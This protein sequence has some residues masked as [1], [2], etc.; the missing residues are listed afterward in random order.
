MAALRD[1]GAAG[2]GHTINIAADISAMGDALRLI[3]GGSAHL[4]VLFFGVL[5]VLLQVFIPYRKYSTFSS[6]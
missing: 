4:Y 6:G 1:R 3:A 5:S 2:R